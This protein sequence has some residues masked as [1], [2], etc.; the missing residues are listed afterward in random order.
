[1]K[2]RIL[3]IIAMGISLSPVVLADSTGLTG[4]LRLSGTDLRGADCSGAPKPA[5]FGLAKSGNEDLRKSKSS[6]ARG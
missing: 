4:E 5:D 3:L 1:M 6:T 2:N